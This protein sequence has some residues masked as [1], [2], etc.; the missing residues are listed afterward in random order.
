CNMDYSKK[1][2]QKIERIG[3]VT[4]KEK[5]TIS[6]V[7]P[8]YN[9]GKTISETANSILSQTYPYFEWLIVD[10]G[11]KDK[12]SLK[13]LDETEK[14]D[15]R[16][17]VFHKRNE[18]P[19]LA[20][21]YGIEKSS[22]E[23]KYMF[24]LDSD[25]LINPTMLECLYWTLETHPEGSFAYTTAVNFG[26]R[27]FIW[28]KY[29]NLEQEK[30][31]NLLTICALVKKED[32]L[33]VGGFDIQDKAMYEDWNLWL[34][35]LKNGKKPVR[36][37]APLFWYR[38]TGNGEF[39]RATKNH[40]QAMKYIKETAA[41]IKNDVEAIQFPHIGSKYS[42]IKNHAN[43]ILPDYKKDKRTTVLY[44]F[45]WMVVG[46]ADFFNLEL[47]KRL[48]Q[49][50]YRAIIL[51]TTPSDNP[52][53][54]DFEDYAEVYDMASFLE[55]E[56]FINFTDYIISSRKVDLVMVSNTEY[57]YYMVP[58]L[59]SK[60]PQIPFIDYI[61]CIDIDDERFGFA[62]CSRD[63]KE[64]LSYTYCCNNSTLRELKEDFEIKNAET[65]YIGVDE[66]KF[67][68]EKFDKK[69]LRD[70]Y[71][72][73][74]DKIIISFVARLADQKRPEMFMEIAK[75]LY[76]KNSNIYF[77]VAG[78][79]P[80][81]PKVKDL[82]NDNFKLLGM[83]KKTD[84]IYAL[85]DLTL[86]CSTF[87]GLALTSYESLSMGV[88]VISTDAG[89]QSE[90]I[91]SSVGAIIHFNE[92]P[93]LEIYEKE[94]NEYVSET[95]RVIDNLDKIKKNCREKILKGF[96]LD[97]M[98][99]KMAKVYESC[100]KEENN[101]KTK[102]KNIGY[103]IYELALEDFYINNYFYIK[104]YLESKF[105][106]IIDIFHQQ[107][108]HYKTYKKI[109]QFF[110]KFHARK[111]AKDIL[112]FMRVIKN[113]IRSGIRAIKYFIKAIIA[114]IILVFKLFAKVIGKVMS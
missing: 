50:K 78:D 99:K 109:A 93:T 105:D 28:E 69:S 39:S 3:E 5:A 23:T 95:L 31:E 9:S 65:I 30:K 80:L 36:V 1:P 89:G 110:D 37:S 75:R 61:H 106:I 6:I 60:Y 41:T 86:N 98:V 18:G 71:D 27:E 32:V 10:D 38:Q 101:N 55:R 40:K 33:E 8:F 92:H 74:Q 22:K 47:I 76:E 52:I 44:L 2:G 84:E 112:E 11:S 104:N 72:V 67:N 34:K 83:V 63:V 111:Q 103:T 94:I 21:D 29:F 35:L 87:E 68:P 59:K 81:M 97:L 90:L 114:C 15:S 43:M 100:I 20:R 49:T 48:D 73:P 7:T 96:T 56:D 79:G 54:Q 46:G 64:Y 26:T 58:Y 70:K 108:K 51:T 45:P 17:K 13:I 113:T 107:S 82:A 91:D 66:Q 77:V 12:E 16:I 62:R 88:P 85:S 102:S 4:N 42:M 53:R 57:G 25:D 19:A 14:M 24:F